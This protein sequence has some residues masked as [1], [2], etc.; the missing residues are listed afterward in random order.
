V[1]SAEVQERFASQGSEPVGGTPEALSAL[2][3]SENL[4]WK[5]VIAAGQIRVE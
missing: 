1:Q 2:I 3:R 5:R 4:K